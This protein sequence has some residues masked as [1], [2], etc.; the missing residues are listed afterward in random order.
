MQP[1]H[2]CR[3]SCSWTTWPGLAHTLA[4]M[5]CVTLLPAIAHAQASLAGVVRDTSGAVLP[6]VTVEA[7]SSV[8]IEKVRTSVTDGTG[9]YRVPEL[10]AGT[11]T[12]TFT[13]P[14]FS[15]IQRQEVA[16]GG[17]G[18][19][20]I[21]AD[22]R[23]GS[24]QETITVT[25]E[26][27][28]V[29]VQSARRG[30][31]L[32]DDVVKTLPATRGYNAIV[33][34]VPS[35]TG[36]SNQIDLMPAM[37]IFY[38]HGG[39]G[40]EGRV[41]VDGLNVGAAFNGG[42]VSGYVMDTPNAQELSLT[43]SGGLGEA[44]VGGT[45]L[46]VVPK[47]GGNTFA[48]S[49]FLSTAG[50]WSQ[51]SNIDDEL[52]AFG[53]TNPNALISNWDASASVG[54]PIMRDRMWFFGTYR[55][56]GTHQV[57][58][59]GFWNK[60]TGDPTKWTYEADESIPSRGANARTITALRLTT[61][62]GQRHKVGVFFDNQLA[63]DGSAMSTDAESCRPR[64]SDWVANG[65]ATS[66]PEASS[67]GS[68]G[69]G[70]AGFG[71]TFQRVVQFTYSAPL[72]NQ[73]LLEA[74]FSSYFSRWGWMQPP[75]AI[76]TLNQVTEQSIGLTYRALD[77]NFNRV[78]WNMNWR[79]AASLVTGAHALKFG[80]QAG[81]D[82]D[83]GTSFYNETRLN[84]RFNNGVP[85]QFTMRYGNWY[86]NQRTEHV[87]LYAQD[88]WTVNRLTLQGALRYEHAWSHFPAGQGWDGPD[89]FHSTPQVFP[90]VV[91][92]PGFDDLVVRG[93]GAYDL[94]GNGKTSL[95]VNVG[96]YLQAA[97]NQDRYTVGNPANSFQQTTARNWVDGNR[98]Y[99]P[100]C[101]LMN[102]AAQN[103]LATGGDSCSQWLSPNFGSP[104][105][106]S[107][108]NPAILEGWGVRPSD[109]QIGASV[110]HEVFPRTSVEIGYHRRW[111]QGF[112]VTDDRALGPADYDLIT[113]AAPVDPRLPDGGGYP[114]ET[115]VPKRIVAS[116]N[117]VTFSSDYGDQY[118]YWHGVDVNVNARLRNGLILQGGTSSGRGVR[119]NCEVVAAVPE[120]LFV[121]APG[122]TRWEQPGS[123]HVVEPFQTQFRGLASY[124]IPKIDVQI[125]TGIQLKPGTGG[126][127][128]NDS[129]SNGASLNANY[130]LPN[131]QVLA[132]LGRP[133]VGGGANLPVNLLVPGQQYGD[134]VNQVDLRA[135]KILRLGGTRTLV[136][137][138]LY[139]LFN[140]NP[141]LTYNQAFGPN[142]LRPTSILMPRFIRFN[143][144]VDF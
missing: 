25:G 21:N 13:L 3:R 130:N 123:C 62:V 92:V 87:G 90:E 30:Q 17:V 23:V 82:I 73:L 50:E 98:N 132:I 11:Y 68:G 1:R 107:E 94:F 59:G 65:S 64:G 86:N 127:G 35:V 70:A 24:L 66:A 40:N 140:S 128:G 39:R 69:V 76:T 52:R 29:D 53:I 81:Y 43:L 63:C 79:G 54:G 89:L 15:T 12:V 47:T 61:Q 27:P 9:Q 99:V 51:G 6:G 95:K 91:G 135:A 41:Q 121:V 142:Y 22:M 84:Y 38:S 116:D 75:G 14:G 46:N 31:V 112:T 60:N 113:F 19:I 34:L 108:I 85:N 55:D 100:D 67:G 114:V 37:R 125:S 78:N 118:Q 83:E 119:D 58:P 56:F 10:P 57:I 138:D 26:T 4:V 122:N 45:Q 80:Y 129:A 134:R 33:F 104:Q 32:S 88:Q 72:T 74:G 131:A 48:G 111:F 110:Q 115:L 2:L 137:F 93:G 77:W 120:I 143:A 16:V 102:P 18:V 7:A 144:T 97:N 103:N 28:I 42:G 109:W 101:D 105:S 49:F 71:D 139:N 36:G 141:G 8:L 126:L 106:V 5:A 117:Y 133:L 136:G 96:K 124:V 20:T 44:E